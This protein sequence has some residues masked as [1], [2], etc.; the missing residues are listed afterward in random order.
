VKPIDIAIVFVLWLLL[1]I[2]V[3]ISAYKREKRKGQQ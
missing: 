3:A 2:P 1:A